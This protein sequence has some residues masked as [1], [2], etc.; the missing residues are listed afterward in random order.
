MLSM[1]YPIIS[2]K[3]EYVNK[4]KNNIK[5]WEFR[6]I[7]IKD[8]HNIMIYET[9]PTGKITLLLEISN[10]IKGNPKDVWERCKNCSGISE[11]EFF[12]YYKNKKN[13]FAYEISDFVELNDNIKDYNVDPPRAVV[14]IN[15]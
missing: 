6:K 2:V 14:Y 1:K 11:K 5:K 10:C 4:I 13:A 7:M 9:N 3:P 8:Y 15:I 12:E